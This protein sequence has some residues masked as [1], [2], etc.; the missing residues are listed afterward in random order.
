MAAETLG[1]FDY[2][3]KT[4]TSGYVISLS[5][6]AD[7]T[8][9][10]ATAFDTETAQWG[11]CPPRYDST[12]PP[13][14]KV[15]PGT[16]PTKADPPPLCR[17]RQFST[18]QL[19]SHTPIT[20]TGMQTI[21]FPSAFD[22]KD[23]AVMWGNYIGSAANAAGTG[24]MGV[25]LYTIGLGQKVVCTGGTYNSTTGACSTPW[26]AN[27]VDPDTGLPNGAEEMLRYIASVG[28]DGNPST[29]PCKSDNTSSGTPLP[30]GQQCGN[31]YFAPNSSALYSIFRLIA[32][33]IFTRLS[34]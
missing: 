16:G 3:R 12:Y 27:Y 30:S 32:G 6:G 26:D 2:V 21:T 7:S 11:F 5:G 10:Y 22:A 24:G 15:P 19:A 34:G 29:D 9:A 23:Y 20:T 33:R 28:D 17:S 25:L 1:L 4:G 18:W 14:A 31:Y 8:G 13:P